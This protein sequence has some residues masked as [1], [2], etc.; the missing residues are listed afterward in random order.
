M[1]FCML[2]LSFKSRI[3]IPGV[4]MLFNACG[5]KNNR[6]PDN[7]TWIKPAY[8]QLFS[9]GHIDGDS[10]LILKDP[11]DTNKI[12]QTWH[13]GKT[14]VFDGFLRRK[15]T[16]RLVCMTAVFAGMMEQL[17]LTE[18]I[19]GM[20]QPGYST[21]PGISKKFRKNEIA[22]LAPGGTLDR[23][24]LFRLKP[25]LVIAYFIDQK[26]L[27]DWETLQKRGLSV[28]YCQNFLENH[29]LGRAEWLLAF[30]WITGNYAKAKADFDMIEEHY[31]S[32]RQSMTETPER[33]SVF[34]NAPYSGIWDV[35]AGD[36]YMAAFIKD[37]G[38]DYVWAESKGTGR[39][40]LDIA[41]VYKAAGKAKFWLNPGACEEKSCLKA[42]DGRL[43]MFAAYQ[44]GNIYNHTAIKNGNGGN[45]WWDY[46]VIRPDLVLKD[47]CIILHPEKMPDSNLT[48][49]K[50]INP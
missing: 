29:P 6:L 19:A 23:E 26:G 17:G 13:W 3:I 11:A 8:S 16:N 24:K 9:M 40:P 21:T 10:F 22:A 38:G 50:K 45:A 31:L 30:G 43:S 18:K 44:S 20:D 5:K 33:P 46:A 15:T 36:S 14:P 42:T 12:L 47:L 35:P 41:T 4:F 7:I 48:F 32:L 49:F 37:A 2:M 34:C 25:D 39:K 1:L 27:N 28:L